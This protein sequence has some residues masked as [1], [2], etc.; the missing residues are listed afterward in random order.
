MKDSLDVVFCN[1][2][3][4]GLGLTQ[5]FP[6]SLTEGEWQSLFK[7]AKVLRLSAA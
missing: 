7:M 3:R 1:L 6:Y 4:V 5:G 2:M